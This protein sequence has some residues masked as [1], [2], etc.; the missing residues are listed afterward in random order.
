MNA[1][2][3]VTGF[4]AVLACTAALAGAALAEDGEIAPD[5]GIVTLPDET[6]DPGDGSGW[7]GAEVEDPGVVED[8][9][10]EPVENL[11]DGNPEGGNPEEGGEPVAYG[12]D[13]CIDCNVAPTTAFDGDSRGG[14]ENQRGG[15]DT[16]SRS[17]A[18]DSSGWGGGSGRPACGSLKPH[19]M[20]P[21]DN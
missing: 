15:V 9:A 12:P 17:V 16:G 1:R 13:D 4:L 7:D 8:D 19:D 11:E 5:E 10:G 2:L 20:R 14:A 3:T 6:G 18:R 21:C